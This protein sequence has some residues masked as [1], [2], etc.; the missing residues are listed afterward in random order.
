MVKHGDRV[1]GK[2]RESISLVG[3][4]ITK[5]KRPLG[6]SQVELILPC[7]KR[8]TRPP[9][10]IISSPIFYEETVHLEVSGELEENL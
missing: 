6:M 3:F 2:V 10:S 7:D 8:R 9:F 4:K 5:G 1:S